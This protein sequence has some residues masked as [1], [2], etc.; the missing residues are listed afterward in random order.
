MCKFMCFP[1]VWGLSPIALLVMSTSLM[2]ATPNG[3]SPEAARLATFDNANGE[4]YFALSLAP[5]VRA[6]EAGGCDVVIVVDTSASQTGVYRDDGFEALRAVLAGLDARDRVKLLAADLRAVP[7]TPHFVAPDSPEMADAMKKLKRRVPLGSTEMGAVLQQSAAE[8]AGTTGNPKALVYIGDGMSKANL[9]AGNEFS[10][11]VDR[12]VK[13]QI[14]VSAFAVGPQRDIQLLATLA[15]QTGGNWLVDTREI[16]PRR[17]GDALARFVQAD[18]FWPDKTD[19]PSSVALCY[20]ACTP[21]LRSDRDTVLIG[22]LTERDTMNI[23]ISATANGQRVTLTWT[24][25]AEA[26]S[27]DHAYLPR[28]VELASH[29]GGVTLPTAGSAGLWE[30][31]RALNAIADGLADLSQ[32]ALASGDTTAARRLADAALARAPGDPLATI[33]RAATEGGS[34]DAPLRA[35][36]GV[37]GDDG[38][39]LAEFEA[40]ADFGRFLLEVEDQSRVQEEI[41]QT[42]VET[43]LA[44]A[45]GQFDADPKKARQS[46]KLL[47]HSIE[48]YPGVPADTRARLRDRVIAAIQEAARRAME[49]DERNQLRLQAEA[50]AMDRKRAVERLGRREQAVAQIMERF[51][52]L[53]DEGRFREA[54]EASQGI[55]DLRPDT[56]L[57]RSAGEKARLE[58]FWRDIVELNEVRRKLYVDTLYQV[59]RSATAYP[60]DPPI[61]YPDPAVWEGQTLRRKKYA[62]VD[63]ARQRGAEAKILE[64]LQDTTTIEFIDTPLA[65]VSAFLKDLHGIEIQINNRALADVGLASDTPVTRNLRGISLR[66]ALRLMLQDLDLTYVIRDEV[67][68]ITTPDDAVTNVITKVYPVA[69]L[70]LPISAGAGAN[71]FAAGAGL[72]GPGGFGGGMGMMGG[73]RGGGGMGL[74]NGNPGGFGGGGLGVGGG[75]PGIF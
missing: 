8:F 69:D 38:S 53:M 28:L 67:L 17:A 64:A 55:E 2:A 71:P 41:L 65:D 46:L 20:P 33:V 45:R 23:T 9:M 25:D 52:A 36:G 19:L 70:V 73:G 30:T 3:S 62:A 58:G 61:V 34:D 47:L 68:L 48:R 26:S 27:E 66:S 42:E 43:G 24:V 51:A 54:Q 6:R 13:H 7:L 31:R 29:D 12:L 56:V 14:P 57:A 10:A 35:R 4:T 11:I 32:R 18:V 49:N 60:D 50:A 59:E 37:H 1:L 40:D 22:K 21:P 74:F 39:L 15:N 5:K 44:E 63:L 16:S 75:P 72:G